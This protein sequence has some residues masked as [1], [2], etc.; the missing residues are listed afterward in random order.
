MK[1]QE[2]TNLNLNEVTFKLSDKSITVKGSNNKTKAVINDIKKLST[3]PANKKLDIHNKYKGTNLNKYANELYIDDNLNSY[4]I[5]DQKYHE[6]ALK[7]FNNGMQDELNKLNNK[8][9]ELSNINVNVLF[10][11]VA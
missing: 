3:L 2:I 6:V 11:K 1:I 10:L 8:I 7:L 5:I 9:Q 4:Y